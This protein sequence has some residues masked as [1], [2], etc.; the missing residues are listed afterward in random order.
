V[1]AI[2]FFIF[3]LFFPIL[4]NSIL[5]LPSSPSA[6]NLIIGAVRPEAF[7]AMKRK[8]DAAR[9]SDD[10]EDD[11]DDD[12]DDEHSGDDEDAM[13]IDVPTKQT[14]RSSKG[15]AL[16]ADGIVKRSRS[17]GKRKRLARER[18]AAAA[19]EAAADE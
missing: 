1:D 15:P 5:K 13:K 14:K 8:R 2:F 19:A 12:N 17:G 9:D 7:K 11:E 4:I 3:L 10:D 6:H 18:A 16:S